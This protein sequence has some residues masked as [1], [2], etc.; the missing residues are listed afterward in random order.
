MPERSH[1]KQEP[2]HIHE[3][4]SK[5]IQ[6]SKAV[7]H[8][9]IKSSKHLRANN[10]ACPKLF[11]P[12]LTPK[13]DDWKARGDQ[14]YGPVSVDCFG[15][16]NHAT[17]H[18]RLQFWTVLRRLRSASFGS[19]SFSNLFTGFRSSEILTRSLDRLLRLQWCSLQVLWEP[20]AGLF[21]QMEIPILQQEPH[22]APAFAWSHRSTTQQ[23]CLGCCGLPTHYTRTGE[24]YIYI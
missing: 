14:I 17:N 20:T 10:W 19:P 6:R 18:Q 24:W 5:N 16:P 3:C 15:W 11:D 23:V 8:L 2:P 4:T 21:D 13:I 7:L 9:Y 22:A 12:V 1:W